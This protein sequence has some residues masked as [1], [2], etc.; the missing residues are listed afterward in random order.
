MGGDDLDLD[1]VAGD[2]FVVL[3]TGVSIKP[4]LFSSI[5]IHEIRFR[6]H[7]GEEF[8]DSNKKVMFGL[9]EVSR[10]R[11]NRGGRGI[12]EEEVHSERGDEERKKE[13]I[14]TEKNDISSIFTIQSSG[15]ALLKL[16]EQ[17][18]RLERSRVK[19]QLFA[20]GTWCGEVDSEIWILEP[21]LMKS[22]SGN[23]FTHN[24]MTLNSLIPPS[25]FLLSYLSDLLS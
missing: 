25:F 10:K 16:I 18:L 24:E 11:R 14:L 22:V 21:D 17:R 12:G 23:G 6:F 7:N 19:V 9:G 4:T 15:V 5:N 1:K 20:C 2:A 3:V 8:R 13:E